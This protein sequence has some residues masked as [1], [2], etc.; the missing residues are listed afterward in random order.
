MPELF[1]EDVG[2]G[3]F[4]VESGEFRQPC[5]PRAV[6]FFASGNEQE[7][8]AFDHFFPFRICRA[9]LVAAHL[10]EG[11]VEVGDDVET[12]T[13]DLRTGQV[14]AQ[15]GAV[16]SVAIN[17]NGADRGFLSVGEKGEKRFVVG[18][19]PR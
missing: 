1:L 3:D 9:P 18:V 2:G 19:S 5:E 17:A 6:D 14:L 16:G 8:R 10:V 4:R 13:Y 7:A 15:D 11:R 12:V